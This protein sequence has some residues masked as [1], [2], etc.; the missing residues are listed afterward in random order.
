[1]V[2]FIE[3]IC[4]L[5]ITKSVLSMDISLEKYMTIEEI[6]LGQEPDL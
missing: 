1:M 4:H 5:R 6:E 2:S 3:N